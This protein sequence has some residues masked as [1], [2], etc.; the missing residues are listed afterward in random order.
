MKKSIFFAI[1]GMVLLGSLGC[2][3][4]KNAPEA[5]SSADLIGYWYRTYAN[6]SNAACVEM[7]NFEADKTGAFADSNESNPIDFS[8]NWSISGDMLTISN[9]GG[10]IEMQIA[11]L[12]SNELT[13]IV[14]N[15]RY[16][17]IRYNPEEDDI[18]NSYF[19]VNNIAQFLSQTDKDE[20]ICITGTVTVT[21]QNGLYLYVKDNSGSLLVYGSINKEYKNGDQI[22]GICGRYYSYYG[23]PEM[24]VEESTFG[25]IYKGNAPVSPEVVS[26]L[27]I[28]DLNK[29][30]K[31]ENVQFT[32]DVNF[33]S[34]QKTSGTLT[35][36]ILLHNNFLISANCSG[37]KRYNITGVVNLFKD[38]VE[39]Y[40]ISIEE[41]SSTPD[42]S[43]DYAP[44]DVTNY[45]FIF[46]YAMT[47][48]VYFTSN[49]SVNSSISYYNAYPRQ[50]ITSGIYTKTGNNKATMT[51]E[52]DN[53]PPGTFYLT[54]TSPTSG[55]LRRTDGDLIDT[56]FSCEYL[57]NSTNAS[58]P[59]S[60]EYKKFTTGKSSLS[61]WWQFG[62]ENGGIVSITNSS[63]SYP[64]EYATYSRN[65]STSA[66]LII[67]HRISSSAP[68]SSYQY[69]LTFYSSTSG[70]Y[71]RS[72]SNSFY[73]S[74]TSG[75]F[76]LE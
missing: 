25:G 26:S 43:N 70:S 34:S 18:T 56:K 24:K 5:F 22:K 32:A 4:S 37:S 58:A 54:F 44:S 16:N 75:E 21:Y 55:T 13:L 46:A 42:D 17:Y 72:F 14:D 8:F 30:V 61:N 57:G 59:Y 45:K 68:L 63:N 62:Q 20:I 73:S 6:S 41:Y 27:S 36:G 52:Y 39:L 47:H 31:F 48:H 76:T 9:S 12:T 65:S 69:T 1:L 3:N 71:S 64:V 51:L 50:T 10:T 28:N 11:R 66:T 33:N 53:N 49:Y 60:I 38:A 40:P 7:W 15:Q 35:N 23:L 67:Y 2:T 29:Y 19:K 74:T